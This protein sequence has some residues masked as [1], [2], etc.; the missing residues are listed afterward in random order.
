MSFDTRCAPDTLFQAT[1]QVE[2][3]DGESAS[4]T[5]PVFCSYMVEPNEMVVAEELG[6]EYEDIK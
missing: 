5:R 2:F 6:L 1:L 3:R 4:A